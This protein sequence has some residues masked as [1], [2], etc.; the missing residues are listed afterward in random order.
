MSE[1]YD[2]ERLHEGGGVVS[3]WLVLLGLRRLAHWMRLREPA[4]GGRDPPPRRTSGIRSCPSPTSAARN[5]KIAD[6][7]G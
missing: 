6:L 1:I 4:A 2:P 5:I 3:E 7:T